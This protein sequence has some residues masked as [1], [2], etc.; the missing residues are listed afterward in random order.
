MEHWAKNKFPKKVPQNMFETLLDNLG[1]ILGV[2]AI[3]KPFKFFLKHF[4]DSTLHRTLGKKLSFENI[5]RK[6]VQDTFGQF[7]ERFWAFLQ[8]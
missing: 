1:K 5:N 7:W 2:F 4:E 6:H 3:L 8:F